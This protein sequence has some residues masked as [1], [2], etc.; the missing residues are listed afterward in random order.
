MRKVNERS[1]KTKA[2][3]LAAAG[4]DVYSNPRCDDRDDYYEFILGEAIF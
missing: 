2:E 4:L 1:P 3:Q